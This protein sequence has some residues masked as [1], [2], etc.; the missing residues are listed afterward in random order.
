M[1]GRHDLDGQHHEQRG[2]KFGERCVGFGHAD[3]L[4]WKC[5]QHSKSECIL[6]RYERSQLKLGKLGEINVYLYVFINFNI[7]NI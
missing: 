4:G 5:G 3:D 6:G 2:Q 1:L 7:L